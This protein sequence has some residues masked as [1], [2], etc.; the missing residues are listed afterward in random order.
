MEKEIIE[1]KDENKNILYNKR[2]N[3]VVSLLIVCIISYY[4]SRVNKVI[5]QSQCDSTFISILNSVRFYNS[6]K[7]DHDY[8]YHKYENCM[9]NCYNCDNSQGY[10]AFGNITISDDIFYFNIIFNY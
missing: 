10:I 2:I 9:K 1:H 3:I 8:L 5:C 4:L 6:S 7:I